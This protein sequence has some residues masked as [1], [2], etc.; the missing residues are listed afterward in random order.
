MIGDKILHYKILEKLGAGGMG[1]VYKAEDTKLKREVAIKFLPKYISDNE[2]IRKRF[3]IEAQAAASLSH[4]NIATIYSI[5]EANGELFIVMELIDGIELKDKIDTGPLPPAEVMNIA[6]QIAEGLGAAHK[7]GIVHR[8]IKPANIFITNEGVVKILDFGLAKT[9]NDPGVTKVGSTVGTV[10]YMSPE[11]ARGTD[12]NNQSDIW[13]LGVVMYQ[14]LTDKRP[15]EGDYEQS[16]IYSLLNEEPEPISKFAID[17]SNNIIRIVEK[18]LRKDQAHRYKTIDELLQDIEL[19][20]AH[21]VHGF[22][23]RRGKIKRLSSKKIGTKGIV[24]I[25]GIVI[26]LAASFLFF[27][28]NWQKFK[29]LVGGSSVT[30]EQHLLILPLTNIGG[31]KTGQAFCDG[32][33]ETLTSKLTQIEQYKKGSLWVVP[34][35]EVIKNNITSPDEAHQM[36]GVNLAVTGSLQYLGDIIRL[37]LN[38][39]DAK[40]VRQLNSSVIDVKEKDLIILQ[41]KSVVSLLE[42]LNFQFNPKSSRILEADNTDNPEAYEY[43]VQGRGYLKDTRNL[44][45]VESAISAFLIAVQKDSLYA[46]ARSGLAQAYWAK[47]KL[48]K[49]NEW[50]D[51]AVEES[52]HAF[53]LNSK[54]AYV[55]I[56]LGTIHEGTGKYKEAVKD[57]NKA[58]E[59][60]PVNYEASRG[61]A[62]AYEDQ[63]LLN[64]A[65]KTFKRAIYINPDNW[66]GYNSLAIFYFNHARYDDAIAQF[67]KVTELSPQNYLGFNGLGAA[68][69]SK[70]ELKNASDMFEKA[71]KI[72]QSYLVASNL[73]TLYYIQGEYTKAARK[74]EKALEINDNDYVIWGNLGAAYYWATGERSKANDAFLH[75]IKLG[76]E[77][78]K[79]NPNDPQLISLLAGF[80]A[81]VGKKDKALED[82]DKSLKLSPD[83]AEIMYRTG[84]TYEQLGD[85]KKAIDWIIKSIKNGYSRSEIENQ[86]ELKKLLSDERYKKLV[87]QINK[88]SN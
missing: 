60:D 1:V 79:V 43:Y 27:T 58:L 66:I 82:I 48:V 19:Y 42:M 21:P 55:N 18:C 88:K 52:E 51:K 11:Q 9:L 31:D 13:S 38:L 20:K 77:A 67:K 74:Y 7:K 47:Y 24:L 61:L 54:L 23:I 30:E 37:T 44:G 14:M 29:E 76:E 41:N 36:Y 5:E 59:I 12:V 39:V 2:E 49:K 34:S 81:M 3:E 15:F 84:T 64:E 40:N 32:L 73:G 80:Y 72:K 86:P 56:T 75:A 8:D 78:G 4:P 25:A 33:M 68:Y 28:G 10:A 85:R 17:C 35:S 83:D 57:F 62:K 69:Y 53:R 63:N 87:S 6:T 22:N 16:V 45:E 46:V 50:A 65:E 70:N 26:I 71:F